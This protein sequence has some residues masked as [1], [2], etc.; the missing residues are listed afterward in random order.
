MVASVVA[1][2]YAPPGVHAPAPL[3]FHVAPWFHPDVTRYAFTATGPV[4][5]DVEYK[6][7]SRS[8]ADTTAV[9]GIDVNGNIANVRCTLLFADV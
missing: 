9:D 3:E 5:P 7:R 1:E 8:A 2:S 4:G 6:Y